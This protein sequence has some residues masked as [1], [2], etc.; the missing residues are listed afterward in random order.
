[1]IDRKLLTLLIQE[2]TETLITE[3][4]TTADPTLLA[5]E[6]ENFL[7]DYTENILE[8]IEPY[9]YQNTFSIQEYVEKAEEA[10]EKFVKCELNLL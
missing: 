4:K 9:F 7:D 10:T 5:T 6:L 2:A 1:M 3:G 8:E